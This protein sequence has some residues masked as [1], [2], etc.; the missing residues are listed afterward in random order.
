M[1]TEPSATR[2]WKAHRP[3]DVRAFP[4]LSLAT[5][6]PLIPGL[7]LVLGAGL[8]SVLAGPD[9]NWD[10]RYY[11]LYAPWA[12]LYDRYLYDI[13]PAQSQGFFNP[14][15]D[16]LFYGLISSPLNGFPRAVAFIM[17]AIHGINAVLV[18]LIANHVIRPAKDTERRIL[19]AVALFL[20]ISGVGFVSLLG[21]TTN[22]LI[23][24]IFVLGALL[25]LLKFDGAKGSRA[26]LL[27]ATGLLIGIAVGLKYTAAVFAPGLFI[28]AAVLA[29]RHRTLHG[30]AGFVAASIAAVLL[31]AGPHM[32]TL[33]RDFGN[34]FFPLFNDI[35]Q[36]PSYDPVPLRDDR[37]VPGTI[38]EFLA[39]PFY[40]ARY[41]HYLVT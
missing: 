7:L 5:F 21:L 34:P 12:Y 40:W 33:W 8:M 9:N 23:N 30:L 6:A 35:F 37:F 20:G 13:G 14:A 36:S 39:Y 1:T 4:A 29:I 26:A 25:C 32:L 38:W 28:I 22:D 31:V 10:L 17:G 24:S 19:R 27:T 41:N 2:T 11:H 15:S 16:F 3:F 18:L